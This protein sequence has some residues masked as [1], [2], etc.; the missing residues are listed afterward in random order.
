MNIQK[1]LPELIKAG[2]INQETAE[3]IEQYYLQKK[4][5]SNRLLIIFSILGSI[6]V[7]LGIILILAHNWDDL[8]RPIKT[9]FAF[10]PLIVGQIL[11]AFTVVKKQESVAWRESTSIFLSL[12]I[13]ASISLVGQIYHIP[14]NI[15][16]FLLTWV[17]LCLPMV[18]ILRSSVTSLLYLIG[19]TYYSCQ[20]SYWSY[21]SVES[22][23]YWLLLLLVLPHYYLLY[24]EKP[25]SNFTLFHNWMIPMS[26]TIVLGTIEQGSVDELLFITYTSLFGLFYL[27]GNSSF[28]DAQKQMNNGFKVDL[29]P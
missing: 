11:C 19:I 6:L 20:I 10:L 13:G 26:I 9:S 16:S 12:A 5:S 3:R 2:V 17:L 4:G 8:S 24:K 7:G 15:S 23:E 18:Y 29:L 28:F 25:T 14:G 21:P 22:Y 27:L 1:E